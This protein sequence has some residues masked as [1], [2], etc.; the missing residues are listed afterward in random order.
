MPQVR[1]H[2]KLLTPGAKAVLHRLPSI[3]GHGNR[4]HGDIP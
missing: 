4:A 2:P 1:E 3:M